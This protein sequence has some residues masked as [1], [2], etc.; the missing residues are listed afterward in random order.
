MGSW[1]HIRKADEIREAFYDMYFPDDIPDEWSAKDRE[2]SH[3]YGLLI[4]P[5]KANQ[6]FKGW[7]SLLYRLPSLGLVSFTE[8]ALKKYNWEWT[9]FEEAYTKPFEIVWMY[10]MRKK[11]IVV[12]KQT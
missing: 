3:G 7:R 5:N 2:K 6:Q 1:K 10:E 4:G 12:K 11:R 8:D 9:S